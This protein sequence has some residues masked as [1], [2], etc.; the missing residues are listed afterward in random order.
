V[1]PAKRTVIVAEVRRFNINTSLFDIGF[2]KYGKK[3]L[4]NRVIGNSKMQ[5]PIKVNI[6]V[7]RKNR[8]V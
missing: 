4:S 1:T 7:M 2:K 3:N 6:S 5:L 8:G